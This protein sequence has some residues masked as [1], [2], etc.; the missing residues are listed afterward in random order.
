MS[1][2]VEVKVIASDGTYQWVRHA[3]VE[4]DAT[5]VDEQERDTDALTRAE[6][7]AMAHAPEGYT[8][9][10]SEITKRELDPADFDPAYV[11]DGA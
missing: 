3:V 11:V 7:S 6:T 1:T 10:S 2:H 4:P 8:V 5:I 9:E